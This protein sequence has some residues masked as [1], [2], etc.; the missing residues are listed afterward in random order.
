M[1]KEH[2]LGPM[3][4]HDGKEFK[5]KIVWITPWIHPSTDYYIPF[6]LLE[7]QMSLW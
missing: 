3:P 1:M 2:H 6:Y 5:Y 4:R 7:V